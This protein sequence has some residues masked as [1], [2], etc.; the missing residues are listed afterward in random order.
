[1]S[2][3]VNTAGKFSCGGASN[4]NAVVCFSFTQRFQ[5]QHE[6]KDNTVYFDNLIYCT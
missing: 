4:T 1:M 3:A 2:V 5:Q 6:V